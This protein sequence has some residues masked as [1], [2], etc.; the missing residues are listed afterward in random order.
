M[1]CCD[2]VPAPAAPAASLAGG[3]CKCRCRGSMCVYMQCACHS[4]PPSVALAP[5]AQ[6]AAL[7][8]ARRHAQRDALVAAAA[9]A[10]G[11]GVGGEKGGE[12]PGLLHCSPD[13]CIPGRQAGRRGAGGTHRT[14]PSPWQVPQGVNCSPVPPQVG[15]VATCWNIPSGV[16]TACTTCPAPLQVLH[17]LAEVPALTPLP[18]QVEQSSKRLTSI[19]LLQAVD[20]QGA[21]GSSR[22]HR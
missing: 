19:S 22:E 4:P 15:Q 16:R 20:E 3:Q 11:G 5:H 7:V 14:R 8:H 6:P 13:H 9:H 17:V 21:A 12:V 2:G 1:L 10:A 18:W